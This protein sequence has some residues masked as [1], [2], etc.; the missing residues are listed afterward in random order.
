MRDDEWIKLYYQFAAR[1]RRSEPAGKVETTRKK[2]VIHKGLRIFN[3]AVLFW[4]SVL[5]NITTAK[6]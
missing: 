6:R 3:F 4:T 5:K 2:G 1:D